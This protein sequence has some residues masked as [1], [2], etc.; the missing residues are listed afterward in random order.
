MNFFTIGFLVNFSKFSLQLFTCF[1]SHTIP[2]EDILCAECK[3][4]DK[5]AV[6]EVIYI[7]KLATKIWRKSVVHF[8]TE[9]ELP[10][11]WME[12]VQLQ[13]ASAKGKSVL[14]YVDF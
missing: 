14:I 8:T 6:F 10:E 7:E 9:D 2:F 13:L 12:M 11:N 5:Q 4:S 3:S 1:R